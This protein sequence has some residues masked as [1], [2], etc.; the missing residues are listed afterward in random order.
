L[1]EAEFLNTCEKVAETH[2]LKSWLFTNAQEQWQ[3]RFFYPPGARGKDDIPLFPALF[4]FPLLLEG[5]K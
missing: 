2:F 1:P 4:L 3:K 5:K